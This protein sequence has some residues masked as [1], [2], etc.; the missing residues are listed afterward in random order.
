MIHQ[1]R[2]PGHNLPVPKKGQIGF[3]QLRHSAVVELDVEVV[4]LHAEA[5]FHDPFAA[6]QL[7]TVGRGALGDVHVPVEPEEG[8]DDG[9]EDDDEYT[10]VNHINAEIG[11][12]ALMSP[13]ICGLI[14]FFRFW[15]A[16]GFFQ[17]LF[18]PGRLFL[19]AAPGHKDSFRR[20]IFV[21]AGAVRLRLHPVEAK[22]DRQ[23]VQGTDDEVDREQ[24]HQQE[25]PR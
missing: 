22:R 7:D 12:C 15:F 1:E 20:Q 18:H 11:P 23:A 3:I 13:E 19:R 25:K 17:D 21:Q 14:G 9:T 4:A 10:G 24:P 6:P 8:P 5:E 16:E 2:P